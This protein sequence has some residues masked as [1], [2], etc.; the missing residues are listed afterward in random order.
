MKTQTTIMNSPNSF[1]RRVLLVISGLSPQVV[2]ETLYALHIADENPFLVNEV[3]V[4]TTSTGAKQAE[5]SL[6]REG[7]FRKLCEDYNLSDI[8]FDASCIEVICDNSGNA[9]D[10]IRSPE[11]NSIAAD[12]ITEKMRQLTAD[13]NVSLHVSLAGGRKTMGYYM[14]YALSLLGRLQDRLSHVLVSQGFE[15]HPAFFYPTPASKVISNGTNNK[16][17]ASDALVTLAK[18]PFVLLRDKL[19]KRLLENRASFNEIVSWSNMGT[20]PIQLIIDIPSQTIVASGEPIT[21]TPKQLSFYLV[22]VRAWK[23][24][25]EEDERYFEATSGRNPQLERAF[26]EELGRTH[27]LTIVDGTP[28][29]AL[30]DQLEDEGVDVRT[31]NTVR[32]GIGKKYLEESISPIKRK[33]KEALGDSLA[34]SYAVSIRSHIRHQSGRVPLY[35]MSLQPEHINI[36]EFLA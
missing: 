11:E 36:I 25:G 23:N 2:T 35:G 20:R 18:I 33:L 6:L 10:D 24:E 22:F 1:P 13:K 19:P 12:F 32:G 4:V 5:L 34:E 28:L 15:T 16:L 26:A 21:M 30:L 27:G 31:L 8:H 14:G 17:D 7:H 9:L 3:R 29:P